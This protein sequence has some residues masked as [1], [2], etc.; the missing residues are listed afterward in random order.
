[1]LRRLY[2]HSDEWVRNIS[3]GPYAV[4]LGLSGAVGVLAVGLLL[5]RELLLVQA[6]AM[7]FV[8]FGLEYT[9]GAF[10]AT[11]E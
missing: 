6:F 1:M 2:G 4:L 11:D 8:L 7:A 5:S 3:R 9:F 10:R